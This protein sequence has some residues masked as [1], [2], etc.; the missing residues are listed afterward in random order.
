MSFLAPFMLWGGLAAGIPIALHFF[1]RSRYKNVPWAAMKFL[2][3]SIEQTSRRLK[4]QELLLLAVRCLLLILLALAF[5]RPISSVLRGT[6]RGDAV[7]AVFVFD[8]SMSMGAQDGAKTRIER[9]K[10][11]AQKIIDELPPHSTVQIVTCAGGRE[12]LRGPRSPANLDQAKY[13]V[14]E[15]EPS[16]LAT[17][18]TPGVVRA[19]EILSIGQAANK[20][21]YVFS[22]MQK[23]GWERQSNELVQ[24]LQEMKDKTSVHLVRCGTRA[25]KNVSIVGIT[26]Q[27][28][29][30]RPGQIGRASCR[31]RV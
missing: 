19:S 28:G 24:T 31:E 3:T 5:A 29:V 23:Q 9:A 10:I 8:L 17:N 4:F 6:G 2:L 20:E 11:E 1:Y 18:L 14:G 26:P 16:S 13:L 30:P 21:L 22:D 7:D 15:L 27:A 25:V 12:E